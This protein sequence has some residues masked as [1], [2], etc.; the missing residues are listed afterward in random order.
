M[1]TAK[2]IQQQLAEEIQLVYINSIVKK[3]DKDN[4]LDIHIPEINKKKGAHLFFNTTKEGIKIG[5][6]CRD[7]DFVNIAAGH[8][9]KIEKYSQ[10]LRI[11]DN[12]FFVDV[13]SAISA[14]LSFISDIIGESNPSLNP[15]DSETIK[16]SSE[17][18]SFIR[19]LESFDSETMVMVQM[20]SQYGIKE[21]GNGAGTWK[22]NYYTFDYTTDW[23]E[24]YLENS[25][26]ISVEN[27]IDLLKSKS[28]EEIDQDDFDALYLGTIRNG[29]TTYENFEWENGVSKKDIKIAPSDEELCREGDKLESEYYWSSPERIEFVITEEGKEDFNYVLSST[30]SN[31][32]VEEDQN[33]LADI[34]TV[35]ENIKLKSKKSQF[36]IIAYKNNLEEW[37]EFYTVTIKKNNCTIKSNKKIL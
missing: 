27:L 2:T 31:L 23:N 3:I 36:E 29:N 20:F 18:E 10:G 22:G 15:I 32:N 9:Q 16:I 34:S 1:A 8:S 37:E 24:G 4:F 19:S 26:A 17:N 13:V 11:L 6:Y 7:E 33:N 5:F 25:E 30:I 12:P 28:L 35:L 21:L 14:A